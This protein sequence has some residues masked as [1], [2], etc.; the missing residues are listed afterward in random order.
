MVAIANSQGNPIMS[1]G[2]SL[3]L[4]H[5]IYTNE[6]NITTEKHNMQYIYT[7]SKKIIHSRN[8]FGETKEIASGYS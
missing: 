2:H 4:S 8:M 7:H 1:H 6:L 5:N 3:N